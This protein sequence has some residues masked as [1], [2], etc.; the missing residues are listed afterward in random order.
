[1]T[2]SPRHGNA[3]KFVI[4]VESVPSVNI[5]AIVPRKSESQSSCSPPLSEGIDNIAKVGLFSSLNSIT[6]GAISAF[7]RFWS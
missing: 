6:T 4:P 3:G 1:M 2:G 5:S 7:F